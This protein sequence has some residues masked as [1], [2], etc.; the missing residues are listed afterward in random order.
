MTRDPLSE[1]MT[2]LLPVGAGTASLLLLLR[3][4]AGGRLGHFELCVGLDGGTWSPVGIIEI[5]EELRGASPR[6]D[7]LVRRLEGTAPP[8]WVTALREP[9]YRLAR[10]LGR[11]T[12]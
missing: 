11:R 3:P 1:P 10:R 8:G 12:R 7:P 5:G 2:T 4:V 9:A 6:F